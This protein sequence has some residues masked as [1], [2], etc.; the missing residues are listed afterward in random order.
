M[1]TGPGALVKDNRIVNS[2]EVPRCFGKKKKKKTVIL[3]EGCEI[4][5]KI[6][7]GGMV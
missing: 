4:S 1:Y 5:G 3:K 7:D 2:T 6:L